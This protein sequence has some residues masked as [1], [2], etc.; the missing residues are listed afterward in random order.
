MDIIILN[1]YAA[2]QVVMNRD[3]DSFGDL[4][5]LPDG[6]LWTFSI[7]AADINNDGMVDVIIGNRYTADQVLMNRGDG[8]FVI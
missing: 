4:T 8:S 6:S 3:D 1:Q 7:A 2:D 5:D